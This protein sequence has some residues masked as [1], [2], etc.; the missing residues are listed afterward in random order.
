MLKGIGAAACAAAGLVCLIP[1]IA[2]ADWLRAESEHFI[3]YGD[4]SE[5][6]LRRYVQKIERF[7]G[8][9]RRYY[10][11]PI[12]H[13]VPKLEI[14]LADGLSDMRRAWPTID[15]NVGG[16]YSPNT[17]RIF[18]VVNTDSE[19]G[20][21]VLFHEYGHH[22]MFQMASAAYPPWFVEGFAEY[23]ATA[24][25]RPGRLE[26]GRFDE[27]RMLSLTQPS[28]RWPPLEDVLTWRV[29][30]S[31]RFRGADY[32]ALS[33]ALTH[34]M[35][36]DPDRTRSLG[37]YLS[38][39]ANGEQSVQA[40]QDALGRTPSQLQDDLRRYLLG[41]IQVLSPQ[42]DLPDPDLQISRMP[43]SARQLIWYDLRLDRMSPHSADE[44]DEE[45]D[46]EYKETLEERRAERRVL[47]AESLAA[48]DRFP[49]DEMAILVKA[50]AQRLS[51][52]P[53]AA[54]VS[55]APLLTTTNPDSAALRIAALSEM[56]VANSEP[57]SDAKAMRIRRARDYL[58]RALDSDPLDFRIYL[59]LDTLRQGQSG[60]PNDNDLMVLDI[61]ATLAPQSF[62]ARMRYAS[63]LLARSRPAEAIAMLTPVANSPHGGS[64]RQQAK[65]LITQ[66]HTAAGLAVADDSS[67]LPEEPFGEEGA[68]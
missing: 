60:Y 31:G 30:E 5:G 12:D 32:Y 23:Y 2:H 64:A 49:N 53:E 38:A 16:F 9:L 67:P 19:M 51:G 33:W 43:A 47:I 56:E 44:I 35:L 61:A 13:D 3:V 18:A 40:M 46:E 14:F 1:G 41:R 22:F 34:Y 42:I 66:A 48:A 24:D 15:R 25:V 20:D 26:I 21:S 7:D 6:A 17:G 50:R 65:T 45:M 4:T 58:S 62:D 52:T 11:I 27:G 10:P 54:L 59:A 68:N 57:E 63:V 39:V 8:L 36:S 29:S 55:L 37:R 28:N